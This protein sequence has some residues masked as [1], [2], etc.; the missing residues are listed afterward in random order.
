[1]PRITA[2]Y[3]GTNDKVYFSYKK[4]N[5]NEGKWREYN[6]ATNTLGNLYQG[7]TVNNSFLSG[8]RVDGS[9]M[10]IYYSYMALDPFGTYQNY[11]DWVVRNIGNNAYINSG[12]PD[13]NE[14]AKIYSTNTNN[15]KSNTVFFYTFLLGQKSSDEVGIWRSNTNDGF[16]S[17]LLY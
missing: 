15:G 12:T 13:I 10:Y 7:F 4:L 8:F 16:S 9:S 3:D 6:V 2:W 11:F 1:M 14:T 17:D 5:A